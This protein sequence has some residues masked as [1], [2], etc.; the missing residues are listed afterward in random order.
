MQGQPARSGD[1]AQAFF[2]K[3]QRHVGEL[4]LCRGGWKGG[5]PQGLVMTQGKQQSMHQFVTQEGPD[6]Q[7]R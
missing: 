7:R 1:V 2:E 4:E 5:P 3:G 6:E